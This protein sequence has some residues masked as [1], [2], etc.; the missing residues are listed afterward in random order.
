MP[1]PPREPGWKPNPSGLLAILLVVGV[2]VGVWFVSGGDPGTPTGGGTPPG[3][4]STADGGDDGAATDPVSGEVDPETGLTWVSLDELP[5]EAAETVALIG[6]GGPYPED[7]DG[8]T[9]YN[10]EG[11]LPDRE[12]GYYT[13]YTVPTP[14]SSDRGARRVVA[15]EPD[16]LFWTA[17]HYDS[18]ERI[19]S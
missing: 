13:E 17:D 15:G 5:P 19:I 16:E 12:D 4:S 11:F 3:F 9:F 6:A 14:G 18:F 2:V 7:E 10:R 8:G 1:A